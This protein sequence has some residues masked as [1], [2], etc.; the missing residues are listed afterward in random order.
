MTLESNTGGG[1]ADGAMAGKYVKA[2]HPQLFTD[3]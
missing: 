2:P 3:H 1:N